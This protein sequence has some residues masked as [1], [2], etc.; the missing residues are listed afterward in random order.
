MK[1]TPWFATQTWFSD[2]VYLIQTTKLKKALPD[3]DGTT[4]RK[5]KGV[6]PHTLVR[7][8]VKPIKIS[9]LMNTE[10]K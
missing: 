2:Q 1:T 6:V 9:P 8:R 3:R 4:K 5:G 7:F 10:K